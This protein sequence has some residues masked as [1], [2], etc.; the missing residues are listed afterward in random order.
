MSPDTTP[1]TCYGAIFSGTPRTVAQAACPACATKTTCADCQL[2]LY[3]DHGYWRDTE[4]NDTACPVTLE[5]HTPTTA[6]NPE[7]THDP[8]SHHHQ[9]PAQP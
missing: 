1:H 7:L 9:P 2:P 3:L 5:D 4:D 8:R 6:K